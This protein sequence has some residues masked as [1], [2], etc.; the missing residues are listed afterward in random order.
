MTGRSDLV[1]GPGTRGRLGLLSRGQVGAAQAKREKWGRIV[2]SW[3]ASGLSQAEFCRRVG[4]PVWKLRWWRKRLAPAQRGAGQRARRSDAN[5]SRGRG[6]FLA[7][8]VVK[9]P[10]LAGLGGASRRERLELVLRD[11]RRLRF[12]PEMDPEALAELAATLEGNPGQFGQA[13]GREGERC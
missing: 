7:V 8:G 6:Q 3:Q 2:Q 11:G 4:I 12:P 13:A 10:E 9:G 5:S 1:G